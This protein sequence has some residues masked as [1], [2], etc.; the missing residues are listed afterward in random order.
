MEYFKVIQKTNRSSM[1]VNRD[2]YGNFNFTIKRKD[3]VKWSISLSKTEAKDLM[4]F[5]GKRLSEK[6]PDEVEEP[7]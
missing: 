7:F 6:Y 1:E 4:Q 3:N 2:E 5:V